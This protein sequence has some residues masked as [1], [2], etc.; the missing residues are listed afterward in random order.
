M[1][2]LILRVLLAPIVRYLSRG[3]ETCQFICRDERGAYS[4]F[5]DSFGN[6]YLYRFTLDDCAKEY[7][8]RC[9]AARDALEGVPILTQYDF[10]IY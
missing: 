5:K 7:Q 6:I 10:E 8:T 2:K 3:E 9:K 4:A 1:I